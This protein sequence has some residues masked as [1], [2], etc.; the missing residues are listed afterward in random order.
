MSNWSQDSRGIRNLS[1]VSASATITGGTLQLDL[2]TAGVYYVNL[3]ADI[4]TFSFTNV[5]SVGASAC[6]LIFIPDGT[7]RTVTWGAG[8]LWPG[9]TPPTLTSTNGKE[10]IFSFITLDAGTTWFGFVGGQNF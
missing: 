1:E 9:G 8:V 6:T 10:D 7:A 4:T 5:Q 2:S 3:N